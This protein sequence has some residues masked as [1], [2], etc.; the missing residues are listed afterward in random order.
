MY[1]CWI[2]YDSDRALQ[3][4][5]KQGF[6]DDNGEPYIP[7]DNL[8]APPGNGGDWTGI[9]CAWCRESGIPFVDGGLTIS[10]KVKKSQIE[11]FVQ[12]V[13]GSDPS[14]FDPAKMMTWKGRA[15]LANSFTDLR[16]F[17][18]QQLSSRLWYQLNADEF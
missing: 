18:A 3:S 8:P 12:H 1:R 10:A 6:F 11:G 2:S 13:Y 14:Y 5:I 16:A 15:Y 9:L 4:R 17:I 7:I